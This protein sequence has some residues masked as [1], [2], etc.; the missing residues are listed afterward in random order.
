M[1]SKSLAGKRLPVENRYLRLE[2]ATRDVTWA[3]TEKAT[4]VAWQMARSAPQ[5]VTLEDAGTQR[6]Q[7]AFAS[8]QDK[9]KCNPNVARLKGAAWVNT[10]TVSRR[11]KSLCYTCNTFA[12]PASWITQ[13]QQR[14]GLKNAVMHVDGGGAF[15]YDAV[16][17]EVLPPNPAA[18]GPAGLKQFR[19]TARKMGWL[20]GLH[21]QYID[22]YADAP[23]YHPDRFLIKE[24]GKPN[25]LNVWYGGLCAHLCSSESLRFVRRN[26][27][28]SVPEEY[29]YH[30]SPSIYDLCQPDAS[31]L[32]C[33]C[34]IQECFHPLHP[35]TRSETVHYQRECLRT[36]RECGRKVVQPCEH[37]KWYAIPDLD[38]TCALGHQKADVQVEEGGSV[39]EVTFNPV[40]NTYRIKG[41]RRVATRGR[42]GCRRSFMVSETYRKDAA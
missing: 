28:E 39:T 37:A 40:E 17:P 1:K 12:D 9:A 31:Y 7:H 2:I 5:D 25:L 15:G 16:H 19:E 26:F 38:F 6:T 3:I 36:V 11:L 21:D 22:I 41:P 10:N 14:T 33:F 42:S 27:V 18:G 29:M 13:L 34:R 24:N 30:N 35:L 20:F 4:G 8:S 23:S 32:D